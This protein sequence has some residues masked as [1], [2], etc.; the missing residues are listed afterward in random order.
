MIPRD[1]SLEKEEDKPRRSLGT[2][3]RI[4]SLSPRGYVEGTLAICGWQSNI[5]DVM[6]PCITCYSPTRQAG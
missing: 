5:I 3:D 2:I 6:Y 4:H 1:K